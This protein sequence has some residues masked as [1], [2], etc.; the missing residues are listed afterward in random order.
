MAKTQSGVS[1][2]GVR[3][4]YSAEQ[5]MRLLYRN[6]VIRRADLDIERRLLIYTILASGL[7]RPSHAFTPKRN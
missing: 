6:E 3:C 2:S 7:K 5:I 1:M 4:N